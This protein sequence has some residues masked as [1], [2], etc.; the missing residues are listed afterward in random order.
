MF[1][2]GITEA[3]NSTREFF[4]MDR[5]RRLVAAHAGEG[6]HEIHSSVSA[7][8]EAFTGGARSRMM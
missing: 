7:A 3:R 6:F 2:D 1:T 4:G 5:L 8:L